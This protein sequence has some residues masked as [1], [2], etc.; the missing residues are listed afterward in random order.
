METNRFKGGAKEEAE[1]SAMGYRDRFD[2]IRISLQNYFS[3]VFHHIIYLG[4]KFN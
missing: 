3:S 4:I 2:H 1:E